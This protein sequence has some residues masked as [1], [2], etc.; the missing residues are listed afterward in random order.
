MTTADE[1]REPAAWGAE[2]QRWY[3]SLVGQCHEV[4]S[5]ADVPSNDLAR[6]L[7][8]VREMCHVQ[9]SISGARGRI[10]GHLGRACKSSKFE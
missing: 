3:A 10:S 2:Q 9:K 7:G 4:D 5:T 8:V 1:S 6:Q